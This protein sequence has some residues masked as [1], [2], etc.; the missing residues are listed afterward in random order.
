MV[1]GVDIR[2][3][4]EATK[5]TLAELKP[6]ATIVAT[7]GKQN[8]PAIPGINRKNVLTSEALH[9]QLKNI[10]NSPVPGS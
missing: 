2:L 6:D 10:S 7:G 5:E 1:E 3:G 9:H 8:I 4:K